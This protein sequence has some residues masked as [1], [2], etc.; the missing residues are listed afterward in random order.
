[1]SP[2]AEG[3]DNTQVHRPPLEAGAGSESS[4]RKTQ[5]IEIET[6]GSGSVER[7]VGGKSSSLISLSGSGGTRII[8]RTHPSRHAPLPSTNHKAK[9]H[10]RKQNNPRSG[11]SQSEAA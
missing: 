9:H 4:V 6:L 1:M 3:G 8:T 5:H 10:D 2:R 11:P 7:I